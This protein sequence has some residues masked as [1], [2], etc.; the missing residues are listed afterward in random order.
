[1]GLECVVLYF[2]APGWGRGE[3]HIL[4]VVDQ[5][6]R[7]CIPVPWERHKF[8]RVQGIGILVGILQGFEPSTR[9]LQRQFLEFVVYLD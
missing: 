2:E 4:N 9:Q 8:K 1:M 5:A 3:G 6:A 7:A